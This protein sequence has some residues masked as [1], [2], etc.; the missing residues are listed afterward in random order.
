MLSILLAAALCDKWAVIYTGSNNFYNYRH[1]ADSFY[2]Y[3][4]LVDGG[5]KKDHIILMNYD[6]IASSAQNPFKGQ[7]FRSLDHLNVYPGTDHIQY[8]GKQCT[9]QNFYNV[10][11]GNESAGVALKSTEDD[12]VFIF[13]DNHGGDGILGVPDGCGGYIYANDLKQVLVTMNEK[14]MYKKCFFPITACYA[15]SVAREFTGIDGLYVQTASAEA[16]SSYAD[17]YD[18]SLGEYLTSEYSLHKDAFIEANPEGTLGELYEYTKEHVTM[19]H[20]KEYGDLTFHDLKVSLFV[21]PR[22]KKQVN[23][24]RNR[25]SRA[26]ESI[27]LKQSLQMKNT[28]ASQVRLAFEEACEARVEKVIDALKVKFPMNADI[29]TSCQNKNWAAYKQ[30][31]SHLQSKIGYL[32]ESFY[33]KTFFFSHLTASVKAEEVIAEINKLI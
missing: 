22:P 21:G 32:G 33:A 12:Y 1:T 23:I 26:K 17:L 20:V 19:S 29:T 27:A 7:I 14:K 9:A 25:H 4:I 11:T 2:Q 8:T 16:E 24:I 15:G 13:F 18:P 28:R 5:L 6:D 30:V 31:L 10:L 3:K